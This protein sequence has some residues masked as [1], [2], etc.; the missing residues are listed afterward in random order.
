RAE[1]ITWTPPGLAVAGSARSIGVQRQPDTGKRTFT[2]TKFTDLRTLIA[3]VVADSP[4]QE[5]LVGACR[6]LDSLPMPA[7]L[8]LARQIAARKLDAAA[9]LHI[10]ALQ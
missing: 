4:R 3:A 8:S 2:P 1:S 7:M 6:Y 10:T 5:D 9:S